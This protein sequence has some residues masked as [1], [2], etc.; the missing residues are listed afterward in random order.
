MMFEAAK[1]SQPT[2]CFVMGG[3]KL[4]CLMLS[5]VV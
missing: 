4:E 5:N 3:F 2:C 1:R